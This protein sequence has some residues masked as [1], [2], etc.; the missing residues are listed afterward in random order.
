MPNTCTWDFP[1]VIK[2]CIAKAIQ[3]RHLDYNPDR[4]QKLISSSMSRHMLTCK[5]SSKSI[6][7]FLS[8]LA[9][10]QTKTLRAIAFCNKVL[11]GGL[12]ERQDRNLQEWDKTSAVLNNK[13]CSKCPTDIETLSLEEAFAFN[14]RQL[15][16][17]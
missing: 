10:R 7:A 16:Y 12:V 11:H 2:F 9:N 6:H 4:A 15:F 14:T 3:F 13:T 17:H 1:N 8:N 5:M